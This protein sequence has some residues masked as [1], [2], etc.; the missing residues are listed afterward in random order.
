MSGWRILFP[1]ETMHPE[2][3]VVG[4]DVFALVALAQRALGYSHQAMAD[5]V[6]SSLRTVQRWSS[7]Q[8]HPTVDNL[9]KLAALVYPHDAGIAKRLAALVGE[10]AQSLGLVKAA[11]PQLAEKTPSVPSGL[12]P[13]VTA[14]LAESVVA[15]AAVAVV[16]GAF[17]FLFPGQT[18]QDD[19]KSRA[20]S[21][22]CAGRGA[23][24]STPGSHGTTT[25]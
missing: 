9:R 15:A 19:G 4:N 5:A 11:A 8:S 16:L 17:F 21:Y 10:T 23:K 20:V 6:G 3:K 18:A 25:R 24:T 12:S 7:E 14:A 2:A 22:G 1:R 13:K